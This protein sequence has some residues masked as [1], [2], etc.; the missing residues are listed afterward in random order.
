MEEPTARP[1]PPPPLSPPSPRSCT[2]S[3]GAQKRFRLSFE[4]G[5]RLSFHSIQLRC[6]KFAICIQQPHAIIE[7]NQRGI[8]CKIRYHLDYLSRS[9]STFASYRLQFGSGSGLMIVGCLTHQSSRRNGARLSRKFCNRTSSLV[10]EPGIPGVSCHQI[11][12]K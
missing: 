5:R 7:P 1:P 6:E 8:R 12:Y 4:R 11:T 3:R 2:S 9:S 10:F